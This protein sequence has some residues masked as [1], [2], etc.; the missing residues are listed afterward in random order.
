[1][2]K[3]KKS[4]LKNYLFIAGMFCAFLSLVFIYFNSNSSRLS[5]VLAESKTEKK[6]TVR[7][8]VYTKQY[9]DRIITENAKISD[10]RFK[11]I[12]FFKK[13][14][15]LSNA[16]SSWLQSDKVL[17]NGSLEKGTW[18]WTPIKYITPQYRDSIISGAKKNGIN[19]IYLSIDSYLDIFVMPEGADKDRE[20]MNFDKIIKDF[21]RVANKNGI[22]VDAEAGWQN[23]SEEG[24]LY[25]PGAIL[26]Y[27]ISFNVEN[28]EK[29]RGFQYDVEVYLLP[30]YKTN[31]EEV[32]GNFVSLV[33][34][35]VSK[36]D[37]SDLHLSVV[38]PEFYDDSTP[39]TKSFRYKGKRKYALDHLLTV[40]ERRSGSKI[41]IMSYRNE[42]RGDNGAIKISEDE[43]HVANSYSTKVIIAQETGDVPPPYI[44]FFNTSRSHFNQQVALIEKAFEKESSFGGT[45]IHYINSFLD[46]K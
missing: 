21:I 4:S 42:S 36:L 32:L 40:L 33:D 35:T 7:D 13:D 27:V 31:K 25:K 11:N 22:R 34:Q 15:L 39:E 37:N 46:L 43:I 6:Q 16:I 5:A 24:H 44:T 17:E 14:N 2:A 1:M 19:V 30:Q 8:I 26:D 41:I 20:K 23:W 12:T 9:S 18:L 3:R 10:E 45:A 29:F 28:E 38:I